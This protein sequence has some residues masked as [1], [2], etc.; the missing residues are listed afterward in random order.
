VGVR[1]AQNETNGS[2]KVALAGAIATDN[3]IVLWGEWFDDGLI[4][5][6][7]DREDRPVR[8]VSVYRR[9]VACL[10]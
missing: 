9:G 1:I 3:Y 2:E 8:S 10:E 4:L 6:A 7:V 5:V